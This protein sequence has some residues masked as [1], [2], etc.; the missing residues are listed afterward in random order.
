MPAASKAWEQ[1][2]RHVSS[3]PADMLDEVKHVSGRILLLR[4]PAYELAQDVFRDE[5]LIHED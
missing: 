5:S 4:A 3:S 1:L 2:G